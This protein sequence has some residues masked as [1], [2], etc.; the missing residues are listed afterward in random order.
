MKTILKSSWQVLRCTYAILFIL[1]GVDKFYNFLC[2][3][4]QYIS[5]YLLCYD[6]FCPASGIYIFG[7]GQII[8]GMLLFT[9]WIKQGIALQIFLLITI[10]ISLL[11]IPDQIVVTAHAV[12]MIISLIVLYGLSDVVLDF[13]N[14]N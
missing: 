3:W 6:S 8:A 1:V 7:F 11:T 4:R 14:T 10:V 2:H 9:R 13:S 12:V 5:P